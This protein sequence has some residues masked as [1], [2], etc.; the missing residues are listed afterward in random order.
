MGLGVH[1][2]FGPMLAI[3]GALYFLVLRS[4]V[5]AWFEQ[6]TSLL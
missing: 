1:V 3:A 4:R 2:P 5:D 6:L